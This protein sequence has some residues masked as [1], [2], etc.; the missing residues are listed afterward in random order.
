MF[1]SVRDFLF[2][3]MFF[4][5]IYEEFCVVFFYFIM[6][7][8]DTMQG[9]KRC[10]PIYMY[11]WESRMWRS[12]HWQ[13]RWGGDSSSYFWKWPWLC[14]QAPSTTN[15][16]GRGFPKCVVRCD[17]SVIGRLGHLICVRHVG[18]LPS[19]AEMRRCAAVIGCNTVIYFVDNKGRHPLLSFTQ[20]LLWVSLGL[21][22]DI[23]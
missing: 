2:R 8:I 20:T 5:Y 23:C 3:T 17:V 13:H 16:I 6:H 7:Y 4:H 18:S 1:V 14:N 15:K 12:K 9:T 10:L 21:P 11:D 22:W 19:L